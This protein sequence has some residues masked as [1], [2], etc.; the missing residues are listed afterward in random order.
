[1]KVVVKLFA[2]LRINRE[3]EYV[4]DIEKGHTPMDLIKKLNISLLKI[5]IIGNQR[6]TKSKKSISL[7][8]VKQVISH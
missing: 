4:I 1:M 7:F 5:C 3:K 8:S 2:S 6:N